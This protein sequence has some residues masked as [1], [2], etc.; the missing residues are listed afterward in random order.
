MTEQY[1]NFEREF[2]WDDTIQQ[3]STFTLL[4]VGLY[5]FTVKSFERQRHTP[6]PQN[7]GKL[8]ACPKAVVSIEIDTQAQK[9][10]FHHSSDPSDKNAKANH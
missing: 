10:C 7:P 3:D 1:N 2:G 8:P 9:E 6:N 4:P 5:E